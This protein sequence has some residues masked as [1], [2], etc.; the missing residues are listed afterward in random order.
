MTRLEFN[1]EFAP[2]T[3]ALQVPVNTVQADYFFEIFKSSDARDFAHACKEIGIGTPKRL[4]DKSLWLDYI[5]GAKGMRTEREKRQMGTATQ[6]MLERGPDFVKPIGPGDKEWAPVFAKCCVALIKARTGHQD[7]R[8]GQV[9]VALA[10][11]REQRQTHEGFN[12]WLKSWMTQGGISADAWLAKQE[13]GEETQTPRR[14]EGPIWTYEALERVRMAR[15][16]RES[17]DGFQPSPRQKR[18]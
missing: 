11:I 8:A 7:D 18:F 5:A 17:M 9:K 14:M 13:A 2:L 6:H 12:V 4:P 16:E 1:R 15:A 3:K 10:F